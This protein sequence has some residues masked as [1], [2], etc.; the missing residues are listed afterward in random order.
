MNRPYYCTTKRHAFTALKLNS[1]ESTI[2]I[3]GE[4]RNL[5][6]KFY[7]TLQ[8]NDLWKTK[9]VWEVAERYARLEY[10]LW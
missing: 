5:L 1:R 7:V 3:A 6:L 10:I 9:S 8:L 2:D 4:E